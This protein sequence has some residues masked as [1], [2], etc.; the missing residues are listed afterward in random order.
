TSD[1]SVYSRQEQLE[2]FAKDGGLS[3]GLSSETSTMIS[4]FGVEVYQLYDLLVF[5]L[6]KNARERI[7]KLKLLQNA[8][9]RCIRIQRLEITRFLRLVLG[10]ATSMKGT[11]LCE[12]IS[13]ILNCLPKLMEP[14]LM[15]G[16]N[17]VFDREYCGYEIYHGVLEWRWLILLL[18][19]EMKEC[20]EICNTESLKGFN[21]RSSFKAFEKLYRALMIDMLELAFHQFR[22]NAIE[23]IIVE[24]PFQC[25]CVKLMWLGMMVLADTNEEQ[26]NF[27][28]CLNECI[29]SVLKE[30]K[31]CYLFKIWLQNALAQFYGQKVL[32]EGTEQ[33]IT[34]LPHN[35]I[36][37]DDTVK[38][39]L[40]ADNTEQQV[41]VFLIL[42]KPIITGLWPV[43]YE[44]VI[45][46]WD[47]F[48]VRLNSSF[49]MNSDS[50]EVLGCVSR[51]IDGFIKQA[52]LLASTTSEQNNLDPK[53]NSFNMFLILLSSMIRHCTTKA[54]KT[55]VQIIFNR[56]FLKLGPKKYENMT[57]QAIYNLGLL[58]LTMISATSFEED[59]SRVSKQMQLVRL[60][61]GPTNLPIDATIKRIV[62]ATQAHMGLLVLFS[63]SCFDKTLHIV[64]FLEN[65]EMAYQKY[66]SRLQPAME[67]IAEGT[68]LIYNKAV[69]KGSIAHG[70]KKLIGP[71]ILK[72]LRH[73]TSDRWHK[74]LD[75]I[76]NCLRS[77]FSF[78]DD[79][80]LTAVN[81]HVMPFVKE[82]FSKKIVAPA[83]IA[84]IA[85]R[86]TINSLS[87]HVSNG[88]ISSMFST[89]ANC[90]TAHSD[91][92]LLYLK[93][94]GE[95]RKMLSVIEE[96]AIIRLWLKMGFYYDRENLLNLTRVVH[97]FD[98]FKALCEIPEYEMF[99]SK[100]IPIELFFRFVGKRYREA[101]NV[102]QMEMKKKLHSIFQHFD[103]WILNP[104]GII[105]QRILAVLVLA[106]KE[107]AQVF[108]IKSNSTCLYHLAF[109]HFFLPFSVLT[110]RNVQLDFVEDIA[111]IWHKVMDVLARMEYNSDPM[112]GDN[113]HNMFIKWVPQFAKLANAEN[114]VR[115]LMLF[116]CGRNEEL[117]LFAM[118]RFVMTYVDLQRCLPKSNALQVMQ[119]LHR[120]IR[121]LLNRKD[122]G[123]IVLFIRTTGLS[124]MQHA[125]MCNDT[126]PT[127][128]IAMELLH[129][130]LASTEGP[131][132]M[133]K[134]EMR[135]VFASFTRKY[136]SLSAESYFTFMCRLADR[137][138]NCIRSIL[139]LVRSEVIQ[140]EKIRGQG[141]DVF[142]RNALHRLEVAGEANNTNN[143]GKSFN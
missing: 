40:K 4:I 105:R 24:T 58:L 91:Q 141:T 52:A 31:D 1:W 22:I 13:N 95:S 39:F 45:F 143:Q 12:S 71:W 17:S 50:L 130:L 123:K 133:V 88:Q 119:L 102:V 25:N 90:T 53:M 9:S 36:V 69:S 126:F 115:P 114:A 26:I 59:Y 62:V 76:S 48:S 138:P 101:D 139:D 86:M 27:W 60:I 47:Y 127:R 65:F 83:C 38:E 49:H 116:F 79:E 100:A 120:L 20:N 117:V 132:N 21:K 10:K 54:L 42:L 61:G 94:I 134:Q 85:A 108:Y 35:Y 66:G 82:Q 5:D 46:L 67:V 11:T 93:V 19:R 84:D 28:T 8:T 98:E 33:P 113:V 99:E 110:D 34:K 37:I 73:G 51:S 44:T 75:A 140:A 107:C 77:S 131:S 136:L 72:Y 97:N 89:Y 70:E 63:N 57:E 81:Q 129:D 92:V 96:K 6:S 2:I 118:P 14:L 122:Y 128:N 55:K 32:V 125:F 30:R 135:N 7:Q 111:K 43:R 41:R 104:N 56:I 87:N 15:Y 109:Q 142:L 64:T 121:S 78:G 106:L 18:T 3:F 103:K 124:V 80:F 112:I 74:V 29:P 68:S 23:D 16:W 137:N